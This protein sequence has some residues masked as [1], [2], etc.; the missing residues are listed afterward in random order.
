MATTQHVEFLAGGTDLMERRRSGVALASPVV[1]P[2]TDDMRTITWLPDGCARIG[3]AVTIDALARDERLGLAYPGLS[4]AAAG[5]ATPEIRRM[6]TIG[7]NLTQ[8]S[9]CWYYRNHW[10]PCLKKGG[11]LCPAR[12]GNHLYG[13]AFDLG[14][15][16]APHPSTLGAAILAYDG[17]VATSVRTLSARDLFGDGRDGARDHRLADGEVIQAIALPAPLVGERAHYGRAISRAHAEWP[18]VET[19]VRVSIEDGRVS[20]AAVALGG[21]APVPL[22][23]PALEDALRGCEPAR[24]DPS[25]LAT[26]A[27]L[28][29]VG[30]TPLAQTGYKLALVRGLVADALARVFAA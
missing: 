28:A 27:A 15:C 13:V 9:R 17:D 29:T 4:A 7:G 8:R 1:L 22:R 5:L 23:R 12:S 20:K 3:A 19:I 25:A 24:V 30:A 10:T 16:V 11:A 6:A 26:L 14:P 18:L 2:V 21:V